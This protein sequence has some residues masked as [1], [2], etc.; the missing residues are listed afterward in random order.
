[1]NQIVYVTNCIRGSGV[2]SREKLSRLNDQILHSLVGDE[3][4]GKVEVVATADNLVP[5]HLGASSVIAPIFDGSGMKT[6]VAEA[7]M[8]GKTVIGTPEAF[9]GCE[10]VADRAGWV[11]STADEF[12]A[13]INC[14]VEEI[15]NSFDPKL[16]AIYEETYSFCAGVNRLGKIL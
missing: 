12:V 14:A 16:R 9:S 5:W 8:Y 15:D 4:E 2:G 7:L 10:N 3:R 13:A 11:C 1:M 6:K